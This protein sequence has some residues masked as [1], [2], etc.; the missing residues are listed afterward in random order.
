[1]VDSMDNHYTLLVKN[2]VDDSIRAPSGRVK[3]SEFSTEGAA[4]LL[5][6]VQKCAEHE[7]HNCCRPSFRKSR[8]FPLR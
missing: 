8:K 5:R 7:L 2:L 1:M 6:I 3:P 4:Y